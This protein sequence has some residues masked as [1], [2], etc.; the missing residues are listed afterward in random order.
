[1]IP[2]LTS[3][4]HNALTATFYISSVPNLLLA[5]MPA[6]INPQSLRL[7]SVFAVGTLFGDIAL[8]LLP[9]SF[10]GEPPIDGGV[11]VVVVEPKR[12]VVISLAIF[13]GF[14]SF[15]LFERFARFVSADSS[16]E[17]ANGHTH[18]HSHTAATGSSSSVEFIKST[19]E[20]R[21]RG[22]SKEVATAVPE[23]QPTEPA[24]SKAVGAVLNL[25]ADA[26]H[27]CVDALTVVAAFYASPVLGA[28]TAVACF[29]HV[30]RQNDLP[31]HFGSAAER[32]RPPPSLRC[33]HRRCRIKSPTSACYVRRASPRARRLAPS[34]RRASAPLPGRSLA[35]GHIARLL[36][37]RPRPRRTS[38]HP[39]SAVSGR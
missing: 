35:S 2:C 16:D 8:H 5:A 29:A 22:G 27:N 14:A 6:D 20:L 39:S 19:G 10:L 21:K 7:L 11:Q 38:S 4:G 28:S 36:P 32:S 18:G 15:F 37:A 1:M 26:T 34:W 25:V 23:P 12:N 24:K 31:L 9:H 13:A 30:R 33:L 3:P 17:P